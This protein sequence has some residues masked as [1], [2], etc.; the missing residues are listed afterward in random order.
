VA[1]VVLAIDAGTTSVR[2][3]AVSHE[4]RVVASAQRELTQHFPRP[5][6]VEHDPEEIWSSVEACLNEVIEERTEEAVAIGITNQR[7]TAVLWNDDGSPVGR[8]VVWQDRRSAGI[9][10]DLSSH[11]AKVR[12]LTGL[13]IDPYFTATKVT[14]LGRQGVSSDRVGTVDSWLLMKLC[15]AHATDP[16]N[17]SRTLLYDINIGQWSEELCSLFAVEMGRLP[18]VMPSS[19][20][21]G[22]WRGIPVAGVAGDQQAALFGNA[23]LE[24]GMSK[25]TYGTGS[26]VLVNAGSERPPALTSVLTTI[27]WDLGSGPVYALEG[28]IFAT[29]AAIQWLRDALGLISAA[30]EIGPLAESV[31]DT[32]GVYLVPA[33]TGLGA[34]Y[35]DPHARAAIVGITRGTTRAHIAR[36]VVEAIAYQV[37]DV[38]EA[39]RVAGVPVPEL[40]VDGGASVMDLLCQ[41]QADQLR[42]PV[43][44]PQQRETTALGAAFLAGLAVGFWSSPAEVAATW[45]LDRSFEPRA[46]SEPDA[47][48]EGWKQAVSR[49]R[50][51]RIS[52]K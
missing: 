25:N 10:E 18:Q 35:W 51:E 46:G 12:A 30:S 48:Y 39:I 16:S 3:L 31:T 17:A 44:R 15:G 34:P 8:A 38:I 40:R 52:D 50:A 41:L 24:P 13:V 7:E 26:F 19:G 2:V 20:E 21:I 4:G 6:W 36:A 32:G 33:F 5:G 45:L 49:V 27:A 42:I 47:L 9:C 1:E 11:S 43:R 28:S 22:R 14:W 37:R 29:G 23:C